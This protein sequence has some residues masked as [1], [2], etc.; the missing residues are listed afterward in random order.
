VALAHHLGRA[1]QMT[2]ILRDLDEDAE[3]GRL[4]LPREFLDGAGIASADPQAVLADPR[5]DAV[6]HRIAGVADR[7]FDQADAIAAGCPAACV[8]PALI[9]SDAYR[10]ILRGMRHRGWA[11]PRARVRLKRYE[12]ASILLRRVVFDWATVR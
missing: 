9:M 5:L 12:I 7:H 2:N 10:R 8:R 1:L 11:A 4:Y 3:L 6:C